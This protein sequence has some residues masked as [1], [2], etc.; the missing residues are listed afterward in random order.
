MLFLRGRLTV[1][2]LDLLQGGD[3]LDVAP[4]LF[5]RPAFAQ[6]I[7]QNTEVFRRWRGRR[8]R[9]MLRLVKVHLL[10]YDVKGEAVFLSG[11]D[12]NRFFMVCSHGLRL[13]F[14]RAGV[15]LRQLPFP[16]ETV[17]V[18]LVHGA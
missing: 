1:L 18:L 8:W 11:I 9:R 5:L 10:N 14:V 16:E 15:R 17:S 3:G 7:V 6:V 13:R 4:E 2:A 12:G